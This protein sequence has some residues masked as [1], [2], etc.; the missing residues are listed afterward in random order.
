MPAAALVVHQLRFWLA[1]GSRADAELAAQG[2]SYLHSL[3]PWTIFAAA[4][5]AGVFLRRVARTVR[6]GEQPRVSRLPAGGLWLATW[7]GLVL[8]YVTQETLEA[9]YASGHPA[10]FAGVFGHGGWWAVPAAAAVALVVAGLLLVGRTLL[11]VAATARRVRRRAFTKVFAPVAVAEAVVK[12][13][14]RSAAGRAPPLRLL[15]R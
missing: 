5:G 2:H 6:T 13:M 15:F 12:P 10:G 1:Y 3:V 14:A 9:L 8:L 11:R 4:V 7:A